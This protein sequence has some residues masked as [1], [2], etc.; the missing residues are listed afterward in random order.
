MT[1]NSPRVMVELIKVSKTYPPSVHAL[2]DVSLSVRSG[3]MLFLTGKSGAGKTTLLRLLCR[4]EVPDKGLVEVAGQDLERISGSGLQQLRRRI[5]MAYQDFRL[6]PRHTVAQ[7]IALAMEVAYRKPSFIRKRT[8]ELLERL[9]MADKYNTPAGELSRGEQQRIAIA[10]A[11]ANRPD[12]VLA[13]EPT[14]NLDRETSTLVMELFREHE[15]QGAT[16]IIATHDRE[17]FDDGGH[18]VVELR[19]GR[20]LAPEDG[21]DTGSGDASLQSEEADQ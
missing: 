11:L 12:L 6:L 13:D 14:G 17:L 5:G 7:N 18:R 16:L 4:S 21:E 3:E 2:Q 1:A 8:R 19:D 10:R 15:E 9:R 20:L